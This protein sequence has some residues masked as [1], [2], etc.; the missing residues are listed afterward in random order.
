MHRWLRDPETE[1]H[2]TEFLSH[3]DAVL[4]EPRGSTQE[5]GHVHELS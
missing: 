5:S 3:E 2:E 1:I 4:I